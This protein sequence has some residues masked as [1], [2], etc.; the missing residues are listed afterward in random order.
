MDEDHSDLAEGTPVYTPK[1]LRSVV[2]EMMITMLTFAD[3][4]PK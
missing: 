4:T 1:V 3:P 2:C